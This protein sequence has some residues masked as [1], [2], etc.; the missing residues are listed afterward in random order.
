MTTPVAILVSGSG[1]HL[2]NF[3]RLAREG[4][5]DIEIALVICDRPGVL[6]IARAE[7]AHLPLLLL[8]EER[9]LPKEAFGAAAFQAIRESGA[10]FVLLAGFLRLLSIPRDFEGRVLN[11][12]PSLLPAFGGKGFYGDRVHRAVLESGAEQSGCTVHLVD[13]IFDHGKILLQRTCPV[14]AGDDAHS[15]AERVFAVELEAYPEA[16]S[17][18]IEQRT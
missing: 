13:E 9:R 18:L 16:L 10:E 8:D 2:E 12:H 3:A 7:A 14:L 15:L 17:R 4:S 11:I 5:L 6:A 1:R